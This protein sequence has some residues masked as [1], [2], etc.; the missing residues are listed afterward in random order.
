MASRETI[1]SS[2]DSTLIAN[3]RLQAPARQ[4]ESLGRSL[5]ALKSQL[6]SLESQLE[7]MRELYEETLTLEQIASEKL[8][9]KSLPI[10]IQAQK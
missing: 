9:A 7:Y 3:K 6:N 10:Q 5:L 2:K 1:L 8:E 4:R